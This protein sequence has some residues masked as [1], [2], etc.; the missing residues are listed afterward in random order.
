MSCSGGVRAD[1]DLAPAASLRCISV[2][3][4][5]HVRYIRLRLLEKVDSPWKISEMYVIHT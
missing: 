2:A 4:Q 5:T 1:S 3:S